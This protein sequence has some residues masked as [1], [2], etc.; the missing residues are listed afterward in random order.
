MQDDEIMSMIKNQSPYVADDG[1]S[2]R[3]LLSLPAPN[4]MR[5]RVIGTSWTLALILGSVAWIS[6]GPTLALIALHPAVWMS[7]ASLAFWALLGLFAFV[8]MD[9]GILEL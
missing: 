3:V 5:W 1:F 9:E 6:S 4:R 2:D 8:S 7:A